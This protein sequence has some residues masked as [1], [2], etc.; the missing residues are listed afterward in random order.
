VTVNN[1]EGKYFSGSTVYSESVPRVFF[2]AAGRRKAD[3]HTSVEN[4]GFVLNYATSK[5]PDYNTY[6]L[7]ITTTYSSGIRISNDNIQNATSV[8]CVRE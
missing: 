8:R 3:S 7:H 1:Q 6:N 4:V 2:P 5:K